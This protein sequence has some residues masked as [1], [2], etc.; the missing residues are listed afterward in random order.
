MRLACSVSLS[1]HKSN[2]S[3]LETDLALKPI[4]WSVSH[5]KLVE[6]RRRRG[7]WRPI[8]HMRPSSPL[9]DSVRDQF[10]G[11]D[12]LA[13]DFSR[14]FLNVDGP[15][16]LFDVSFQVGQGKNKIKLYGVRAILGVRSRY[17]FF[18]LF[19]SLF[20]SFFV[21][22]CFFKNHFPLFSSCV[23]PFFRLL[24]QFFSSVNFEVIDLWHALAPC[25]DMNS[26]RHS[27]DRFVR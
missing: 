9:L 11:Y 27:V 7:S 24:A 17:L 16:L 4:D 5:W 3:Q 19:L 14:V 21:L 25:L 2:S 15:T 22:V 13:K 10:E 20:F 23:V 12:Q 1:H 6:C 26:T 18:S 8:G